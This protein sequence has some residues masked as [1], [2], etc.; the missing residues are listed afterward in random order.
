[1]EKPCSRRY[2]LAR[3]GVIMQVIESDDIYKVMVKIGDIKRHLKK[4]FDLDGNNQPWH[5]FDSVHFDLMRI[6]GMLD[7]DIL[8]LE[9]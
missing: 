6:A 9:S 1:M 3:T 2:T 5:L 4:H 8:D 7:D